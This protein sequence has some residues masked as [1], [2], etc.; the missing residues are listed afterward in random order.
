MMKK[1]RRRLIFGLIASPVILIAFIGLLCT[2]PAKNFAYQRLRALLSRDSGIDLQASEIGLN[3]FTGSIQLNDLAIRSTRTPQ[4]PPIFR[5]ARVAA[6]IGVIDAIR[7]TW[8]IEN[9]SIDKP[10]FFYFV[11]LQGQNNLPQAA[12]SSGSAPHILISEAEILNGSF[13]YQN[14]QKRQDF[15]I[16]RW[17]VSLTGNSQTQT[18]HISFKSQQAALFQSQELRI[19]IEA[20]EISAALAKNAIQVQAA[21]F[22]ASGSKLSLRGELRDFSHPSINL[23]ISPDLDLSP[24]SSI[25]KTKENFQ[26]KIS[27]SIQADGSLDNLHFNAQLKGSQ[28]NAF[29]YKQSDVNFSAQGNWLRAN[30]K[31]SFDNFQISSTEGFIKGDAA[32]FPSHA[33][34]M[35]FIHATLRDLKLF[36]LWKLLHPSFDL[37]SRANGKATLQWRGAFD[38]A[39]IMAT[40]NLNLAATRSMPQRNLLPLSGTINARLQDNQLQGMASSLGLFGFN[41]SGKFTLQNFLIMEGGFQGASSNIGI[42]IQQI[43]QFIGQPVSSSPAVAITGPVQFTLQVGGSLKQPQIGAVIETPSLDAGRLKSLNAKTDASFHDAQLE[44]RSDFVLPHHSSARIQGKFDFS[45]QDTLLDADMQMEAVPAQD[46]TA[47]MN[48]SL[49][50]DGSINASAHIQGPLKHLEGSASILGTNLSLYEE[51]LGQLEARLLLSGNEIQTSKFTLIR[52]PET[53]SANIL[54]G[55]ISYNLDSQQFQLQANGKSLV[56]K[57]LAMP[58]AGSIQGAMDVDISGSGTVENPYLAAK[59]KSADLHIGSMLAGPVSIAANLANEAISINAQAPMLNLSAMVSGRMQS[60]YP[61]TGEVNATGFDLSALGIKLNETQPLLGQLDAVIKGSGNLREPKNSTFSANIQNLKLQ[62]GTIEV[63]TKDPVALEYR[64]QTIAFISAAT[65]IS[66]GSAMKISGNLPLQESAPDGILAV[67][68]QMDLSEAAAFMRFPSGA[69]PE[70]L[71]KLDFFLIGKRGVFQSEGKITLDNATLLIPNALLPLTDIRINASIHSGALILNEARAAWGP[72]SI[73]L[74]GEFPFGLLPS[75]IPFKIFRKN[76][77]AQFALDLENLTPEATGA[78]PPD[79]TGRLSLLV[80]GQASRLDA[81]SINASV[82]FRELGFKF[83]SLEFHQQAS[84]KINIHNGIASI[85]QMTIA[86]PETNLN[87]NGS[88]GLYPTGPMSLQL[89]GALDSGLLTFSSPSIKASGKL[90]VQLAAGGTL[91]LPRITGYAEM[92]A[93]KLSLKNP[94]NLADSLKIRLELS[95]EKISIK[96]F[97]GILNGGSLN[98]TGNIGYRRGLYD[99]IQLEATLQDCFLNIF[100]G[101]KS[102]VSGTLTAASSSEETI[103]IGGN[104]RIQESSYRESFEVSGQ[105]MSYLKSQQAVIID[106]EPNAFLNRIRLNIAVRTT[107]PLLVKNNIARVEAS[108]SNLKLAGSFY[109]PSAIG[110][111]TLNEGGEI[112]LNQRTYYINRGVITFANQ[113]HIEPELNISAQTKV[114]SY[115]IT[116]Q[117]SGTA[118][119]LSTILSSE[120]PLAERDILSLL[121]TGKTASETQG[122]EMQLVRTQALSLLAGQA[123]EEVTGEARKALHLST[124]R[125]DPG[126]ITSESDPGARLTLGQDITRNLSLGYSMNLT[127]G[128]DQIWAAQYTIIRRLTT[129]AIKQQDNSYR[130]EFRHDLRFGG[131]ASTRTPR[132]AAAKFEIGA[133]QFKGGAPFSDKTLRSKLSTEPGDTYDFPKIQKGLDRL[134]DFYIDQK[135]LEADIRMERQPQKNTMDLNLTVKPGPA[136]EFVFEGHSFPESVKDKLAQA[137]TNGIYE[138]ERLDECT[139]VLRRALAQEGFLQAEITSSVERQDELRRIQF[140]ILPGRKYEQTTLTFPGSSQISADQLKTA[141]DAAGLKPEVLTNPQHVVDYLNRY[142]RER[143]YLQAQTTMPKLQADSLSGNGK[144]VIAIK[145]GPLFT[146]GNLEFAG[147]RA[148]S[149]DELWV[150]IPTS[151]GSSY[152]PSSLRNSAKALENLYHSKGY[153]EVTV[154]FRVLQDTAKAQANLTFQINERRQSL[155]SDI[156]IEG[157]SGTNQDFIVKQLDFQKGDILN[158]EKINESRKRLYATGVYTSVDIQSE[159]LENSESEAQKKMRI[160]IRL[161]ENRPY[162]LQYGLFYDTERGLGGLMEAQNMNVLG[163]A[164]NLGIRLRY[165]TDLK[166]ARLYYNQPFVRLLHL[167]FDAGAFVQ[168][169]TRTSYTAKRI[170]FSLIQEKALTKGF[171]LDYGYRYD[172]VRW[173]P[174]DAALDPTIFQAD[175]PVARLIGTLSRDTRDNLLDATRGEFSSHSLEFGPHWLGS[176]IGFIRYSGQ[177]FRYVPLDKYLGMKN[178]NAQ[179][180]PLP[181]KFIYAGALRLG[182]TSAFKGKTLDSPERFFAGGGTTIRGF[183]QDFLGPMTT[184]KDGTLRPKGG[185]ASLLFNNEIRFPITG[186]L[187]GVAFLDV[188]N[189]YEKFSD[190]NF[191]LRKTAGA[192]LRLKIKYIPLRFDYGFKLDRKTGESAGE[193]FFSIGQA[194]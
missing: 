102:S 65:L 63:H 61:F 46:I 153:N 111:I 68:G 2:P 6:N 85:S 27:G 43:S 193:Y 84:S 122:N 93:G 119:R 51:P 71:L 48:T 23:Q 151:S 108:A 98:I 144:V 90:Q 171:R 13:Q 145:E 76:G 148:F 147:N 157:N 50:I 167:K 150:V 162:R 100:E 180:Q 22:E 139:L 182:L 129:Q 114:G 158:F 156:V 40:A 191:S 29:T 74:T 58:D 78:F 168:Q 113:N 116:L 190:F 73:V 172:H 56:L 38:L 30:S 134:R 179:G 103:L 142:Y 152:S 130:F 86:G 173:N 135:Y 140:H 160:R 7:G 54:D 47:V 185:E 31:L 188:G 126:L 25:A 176:E 118:D 57:R 174:P 24:I 137:W 11:G 91:S 155:I 181:K 127:N 80:T 109:E 96:E 146:I 186:I 75:N 128:A 26:G 184:L 183:K 59:L 92:D 69:K 87:L 95:P 3:L 166:E 165:D 42:D 83:G 20:M 131:P 62:S 53:P 123:G 115:E 15:K 1:L 101:L 33:S 117:L 106:E 34:D 5:A 175:V 161:R 9:L 77:P 97:T 39:K 125:I 10:Q 149:Y 136:I 14:L 124:F 143:G 187:H 170:G 99:D 28:I 4:L 189:V 192:G 18:H 89:S 112:I 107:T 49:P 37:A 154:T 44:F 35:S 133:I 132:P 141:V 177:Y 55:A 79:V 138:A 164:S 8:T 66:G 41:T 16:P 81:R 121:V 52:N 163:R 12:S 17:R 105:L 178:K 159:P 32:L 36:P 64:N 88:V 60:P 110:R 169:E 67:Q 82:L 94:R 120:P 19:P 194:F 70:G 45:K 104:I 72:G 21:H